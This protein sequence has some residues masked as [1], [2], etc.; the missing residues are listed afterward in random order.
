MST[1][2][3]EAAR[4]GFVWC[5]CCEKVRE[6]KTDVEPLPL[7]HDCHEWMEPLLCEAGDC[8]KEA[9]ALVEDGGAWKASCPDHK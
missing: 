5:P 7:C 4:Y 9:T 1:A 2:V 6:R 3:L 8:E